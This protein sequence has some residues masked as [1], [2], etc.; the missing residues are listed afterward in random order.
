MSARTPTFATR[1]DLGRS[2]LRP[3]AKRV[4]ASCLPMSSI[5]ERRRYLGR[6]ALKAIQTAPSALRGDGGQ[7][8]EVEITLQVVEGLVVDLEGP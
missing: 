7:L 1:L 8:F 6:D 3:E 5:P 2:K 4:P